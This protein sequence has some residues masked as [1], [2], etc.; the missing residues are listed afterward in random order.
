MRAPRVRRKTRINSVPN[1]N[2]NKHHVDVV[3]EADWGWGLWVLYLS[4]M[5]L[6]ERVINVF[7][8]KEVCL[9]CTYTEPGT[10]NSVHQGGDI[11]KRT[12]II[13]L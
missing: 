10:A 1:W 3:S 12:S 13:P 5:L 7:Y 11:L 2:W 8:I 4:R 6:W 9:V